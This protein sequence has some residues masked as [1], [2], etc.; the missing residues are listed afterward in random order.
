MVRV[1]LKIQALFLLGV[2]AVSLDC[3]CADKVTH[4]EDLTYAFSPRA[5][6]LDTAFAGGIPAVGV[7]E[8]ENRSA[9]AI[10]LDSLVGPECPTGISWSPRS[11]MIGDRLP[12]TFRFDPEHVTYSWACGVRASV[13]GF[14]PERDPRITLN[15]AAGEARCA[16]TPD[17]VFSFPET[18][19]GQS[20]ELTVTIT[21]TTPDPRSANQFEYFFHDPSGDCV[22]FFLEPADSVDVVGPSEPRDIVISF[23]PDAEG[24]FEC[25]R[26]L[27]TRRGLDGLQSLSQPHACPS[28]IV[29]TGTSSN[30]TQNWIDCSPE[31]T[32]DW[33]GVFGLSDSE[34][35]VAGT[36]GT[37]LSSTGSCDWTPHGTGFATVNLKDIWGTSVGSDRVVW[38]VGNRIPEPPGTGTILKYE[39]GV[40]EDVDEDGLFN[41]AAVWGSG[42][43]DVYAAGTGVATDF[44]NTKHWD[45][46]TFSTLTISWSGTDPVAALSGTE[47]S[48]IWAVLRQTPGS[49]FRSQGSGWQD[50]TALFMNK[51]LH[52]VW[53]RGGDSSHAVY[54]VGADG[55]IYHFDPATG[56]A[57][58]SVPGES[59]DFYGVWVSPSG[60]VIVVGEDQVIYQGQVSDTNWNIQGL[61]QNLPPGDLLDVW[62][63]PDGSVYAVGT[64]GVIVRRG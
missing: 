23:R 21:N 64:N 26:E 25:R 42:P 55:A 27:S 44:P 52:D 11:G 31:G 57:D 1:M 58:V 12:I 43:D 7:V 40:W 51:P 13:E 22:L 63:G 10:R 34:V 39:G 6:Y 37:V 9:E 24:E 36:G 35:Y 33:H 29:W 18:L 2:L 56:W 61:P 32:N 53:A 19:V 41:F 62:G 30:P 54:A 16:V 8:I 50:Q 48:D 60:E 46:S 15:Y 45:G 49:V 3:E 20:T 38:A 47:D 28:G 4:P 59:R 14:L 5:L 17:S